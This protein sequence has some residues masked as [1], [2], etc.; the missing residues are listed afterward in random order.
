MEPACCGRFPVQLRVRLQTLRW[1]CFCCS[2]QE[3]LLEADRAER[4]E[5]VALPPMTI[6]R[7]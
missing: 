4:R 7:A 6:V 5:T 1:L 3:E 2:P